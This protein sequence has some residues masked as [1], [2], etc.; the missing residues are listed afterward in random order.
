MGCNGPAATDT[1]SNEPTLLMGCG[2]AT[3]GVRGR[4]SGTSRLFSRSP[5][6]PAAEM[7][8]VALALARRCEPRQPSPR[9]LGPSMGGPRSPH[10]RAT[11]PR[12]VPVG[13][14]GFWTGKTGR[15]SIGCCFRAW[16]A[17]LRPRR[18]DSAAADPSG[19][20]VYTA[21]AGGA[22]GPCDEPGRSGLAQHGRGREE[23]SIGQSPEDRQR[24]GR[25]ARVYRLGA[26]RFNVGTLTGLKNSGPR[27]LLRLLAQ[28]FY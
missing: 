21:R 4:G 15:R 16:P 1:P 13:E 28:G 11:V 24:F 6:L 14:S 2:K 3:G 19:L 9:E 12:G 23:A 7:A 17:F 22:L 18:C 10:Q 20:D 8:S 26:R 27:P 25:I 5:P